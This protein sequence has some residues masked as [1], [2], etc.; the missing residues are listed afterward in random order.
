MTVFVLLQNHFFL[1][2]H[3]DLVYS[4]DQVAQHYSIV[5]NDEDFQSMLSDLLNH[6]PMYYVGQQVNED[7]MNTPELSMYYNTMIPLPLNTFVDRERFQDFSYLDEEM[8]SYCQREGIEQECN[9]ID[10]MSVTE[11]FN[12][13]YNLRVLRGRFFDSSD[14]NTND[15]DIA[16]PVVLGNDYADCF[17]VGDTI[18]LTRDTAVVIG[19]L[20]DDMYMSLWG[21]VMYLDDKILTICPLFPRNFQL[22]VE[23]Y[24]YQKCQLLDCICCKDKTIDV[25]KT[26]NGITAS[27]G[28]YTYEV[29]PIDGVEISETKNVSYRNVVLIGICALIACIICTCS[30]GSV[31]YNRTVQ[32][33]SVFCVFMCSGIPLWKINVSIVIEMSLFLIVSFFPTYALSLSEY[34]KLMVQ[35]WYIFL[36]SGIIV[37]VSLIPVFVVNKASNIDLLIRDRIV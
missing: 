1:K 30:L 36:F 21:D 3:F 13:V 9:F 11:N 24:N 15:P 14:R 10:F 18:K 8:A 27:H 23:D 6:S 2:N 17:E 29:Q 16:V 4:D 31:L 37:L 25:Q 35:P 7:I 19:I 20:E 34:G 32:D 33:R 28:Y 22:K 26:I 12:E 5:M